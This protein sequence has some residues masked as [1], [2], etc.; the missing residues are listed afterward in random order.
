MSGALFRRP[1]FWIVYALIGV[2]ALWIASQLFPQA[3]PI[4]R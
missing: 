3:I 4:V 1:L 2:A